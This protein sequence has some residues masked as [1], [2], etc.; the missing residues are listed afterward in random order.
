MLRKWGLNI[1]GV[2]SSKKSGVTV[3][4]ADFLWFEFQREQNIKYN[5]TLSM[6]ILQEES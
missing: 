5:I 3:Q 6:S 4:W 2:Y 1:L